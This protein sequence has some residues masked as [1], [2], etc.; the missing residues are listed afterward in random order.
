MDAAQALAEPRRRE[1]LRLVRDRERTVND[2]ASHFDVTQPAVSQHL[3]A[4][5]GAGL[6]N[7]RTQG[8]RRLY[9]LR[10]EG[11]SDLRTFIEDLWERRLDRLRDVIVSDQARGISSRRHGNSGKE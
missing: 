11:L 10:P 9:S 7:V 6:V 3:K 5:E 4:L 8:A 1:I 2:I